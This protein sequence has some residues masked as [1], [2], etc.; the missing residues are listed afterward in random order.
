MTYPG[1]GDRTAAAPAGLS[2]EIEARG[3]CQKE[4]GAYRSR[5]PHV[6]LFRH[7]VG[8]DSCFLLL[9]AQNTQDQSDSDT[10]IHR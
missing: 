1:T 10:G 7:R 8:A 5:T 9:L 4:G 3:H 2:V 6:E